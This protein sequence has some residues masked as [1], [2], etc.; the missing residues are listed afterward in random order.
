M[1]V[2]R[3]SMVRTTVE[4]TSSKIQ[5]IRFEHFGGIIG[6]EEPISLIWVDRDFLRHRGFDGG[7]VWIGEDPGYLSAPVEMEISVTTR[8][9]LNC[10]CCYVSSDSKGKDASP[11]MVLKALEVA[12]QMR[13]FH[14]AFGGGEPLLHPQLMMFARKAREMRLLPT[15]T[16]N[17]MLVTR[18]WAEEARNLFARVNVSVDLPG[19][20]RDS[21]V[22]LE[23]S[24]NAVRILRRAGVTAG[25]NFIVTSR[26]FHKLEELFRSAAEAGADSILLLRPK[27]SG[28]GK[29]VY[30]KLR[31]D[32]TEQRALVPLILRLSRKYNLAFHLDCALAPLIL[33][34]G[35]AFHVLD[36]L[37]A[38]GC[39]A[40][41]L[42]VTVDVE[43]MV[44]PCSHLDF[45]VGHVEDLPDLWKVDS[46]WRGFR[47]RSSRLMGKCGSCS[48]SEL[49]R[50]G[51][52]VVNEYR[53]LAITEP[54]P[55]IECQKTVQPS[56][57]SK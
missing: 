15:M 27:P 16:T 8:C 51:C 25:V 34:S 50:G 23:H 36:A 43:G 10:P 20:P 17:G 3:K 55:D 52:A 53:G 33:N 31:L 38:F 11:D 44:H 14:V 47:K 13:V 4:M 30:E 24:L 41:D 54:D 35:V 9:N 6:T 45:T 49:C 18:R 42:L 19:G 40:A 12:S 28:R 39:I 22:K 46:A 32:A 21:R 56:S 2:E 5:K 48:V 37:G 57:F 29:D 7:P 26:N 1:V